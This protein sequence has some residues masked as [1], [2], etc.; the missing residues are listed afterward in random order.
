MDYAI[1]KQLDERRNLLRYP[2]GP[3]APARPIVPTFGLFDAA[4]PSNPENCVDGSMDTET[5][6]GAKTLGTGSNFGYA[7]FDL[8]SIKNVLVM[9]RIKA[10]VSGAGGEVRLYIEGSDDNNTANVKISN[11]YEKATI[12]SE[13]YID[14]SQARTCRMI[15]VRFYGAV[16]ADYTGKLVEVKAFDLGA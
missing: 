7:Y 11:L 5:G 1:A 8:G 14:F 9:A 16:A 13:A 6:A 3:L 12:T 15:R 10:S 2:D 4:T